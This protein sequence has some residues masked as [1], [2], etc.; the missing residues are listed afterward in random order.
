MTE[1]E[2]GE[3]ANPSALHVLSLTLN[4]LQ[5]EDALDGPVQVLQGRVMGR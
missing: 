1:I 4:L 2:H 3:A 5:G